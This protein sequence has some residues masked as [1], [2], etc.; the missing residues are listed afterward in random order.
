IVGA[1]QG[2]ELIHI[3]APDVSFVWTGVDGDAARPGIEDHAG[4]PGHTGP[5]QIAPIAQLGDGIEI[6]GEKSHGGAP[7]WS[8]LPYTRLGGSP[9]L[10]FWFQRKR[11]GDYMLAGP[12]PMA[13]RPVRTTSTRPSGDI[14]AIKL[15][16]LSGLPVTSKTKLSTVASTI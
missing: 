4:N 15:S 7:I 5:R 2:R 11:A 1:Q 13:A 3:S 8:A 9:N 10:S 16:I 6:D 12:R 14:R